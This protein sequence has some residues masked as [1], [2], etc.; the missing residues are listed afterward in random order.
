MSGQSVKFGAWVLIALQLLMAFGAIWIFMRM[1]PAIEVI[2]DRNVISLEASE[3]MLAIL[4]LAEQG[5]ATDAANRQRFAQALERAQN[6]LTE[7]EEPELI[8]SIAAQYSRA[9]AGD[10]VAIERTV[11]AI[12]QLGRIN[13]DAMRTADL[14]ARQ[15]GMGGAWAVVF[16]ASAA[17][18]AGMLFLHSLKR[19]LLLPLDEIHAAI[20]A[21]SQ[22][23]TLRRCT[24]KNVPKDMHNLMLRMNTILDE[25]AFAGTVEQALHGMPE[26]DDFQRKTK[27]SGHNSLYDV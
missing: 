23:D 26:H 12:V 1:A 3:E 2:I 22:G 16:M 18:L 17:F 14:Q 21:F 9:L 4:T 24:Q 27:A 7:K 19:N 5:T 20:M 13:R 25:L 10:R 11:G 15:L 6:N 8:R